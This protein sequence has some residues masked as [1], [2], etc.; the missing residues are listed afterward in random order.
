MNKIRSLRL[1]LPEIITSAA[2]RLSSDAGDGSPISLLLWRRQILD[3]DSTI[4]TYWNHVFLVSSILALFIDPLYFYVPYVGGP[5]CI[6]ANTG[7]AVLVT[8][9]RTV[10]DL[11]HL[12]HILMKF[13]TAFVAPSSRVF[14]RGELVMDSHEIAMRYMK[15]D[16]VIDVAAMLPLPQI[17]IW[18]VIPAATNASANHANS[19]LALI[20]LVQYIPRLFIIFPLNQRI[21]KTTGFIAKTAWAGAAYNL[22]L[23]ILASHV[24][25]A[26]WYLLSIGRQFSCWSQVC[27]KENALRVLDCLPS[28][29]NCKSLDLP[30]RQYW[31]N[32]TQVLSH[33]DATSSTTTFKFGMFAEAF[34]SEVAS[35]TFTAKY[36]YCL[37]WGIRNLS[38]YGQNISTSIY[39]GETLFCITICIFGLILFSLL[40]GNMQTSLQSMSVRVEEWRVKRRDTEEWMRHRQLPPDL[41][42]RVR[43]FVQYKWL[44]TRGVDEESI[45]QSL[46]TDLR[47]EIQRHLCLALVRRVPFFSQMDDQLL[48]AICGCLVS[49]LSTAG[50]YIFR[51]GDPVNEM[52]FIIR[53]QL[54]SSTTNGGRSGFFN[55]ITLRPGDF[56][57]EE[58]LTWALMP[59]STLNLPSSTR[60]VRALSE[61]EAFALSAEDLK[62]VAHQFKR[63]QSKKLQH[64]FRYY[65]HQWRTWGACFIQSAWRRYRRR[66]L[67]KELSLHENEAYY[68]TGE[69][70]YRENEEEETG[71]Y[72]YGSGS[73]DGG[74]RLSRDSGHN[75]QN[76]GATILAS[77][78]AANTKRG[79]NQKVS[80]SSSSGTSGK[81]SSSSSLKMPQLF[82]PDEPDFSLDKEEV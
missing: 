60:T 21:I 2:N 63:L 68:Y 17:V 80:G 3:P 78:F 77:K 31:Q 76:L 19:T 32:V 29:L 35:E 24:L 5:A 37:W 61:V 6:A 39:I 25:G 69:D 70:G 40:I 51:E 9:F 23:Y 67:A 38:S 65:S 18:L 1:L 8:F 15:T 45:L 55:S 52:L 44:A 58:L 36:L 53:G 42:E 72:Y 33:C 14:G 20:V 34:T 16:F 12:L 26:M 81:D 49:S 82:K 7:F 66:K 41:Q 79:T 28:F 56:C 50:T 74:E 22:L 27:K 4:V 46:P 64:A 59:N 11:F 75:N 30:E 13:R 10:A 47:R 43:R 54:E 48:D 57:G 73:D 71:E 62:F